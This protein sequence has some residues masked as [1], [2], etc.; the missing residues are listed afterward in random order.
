MFYCFKSLKINL[1]YEFSPSIVIKGKT[2]EEPTLIGT[3]ALLTPS[4]T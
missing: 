2:L 4:E 1:Y 3:K